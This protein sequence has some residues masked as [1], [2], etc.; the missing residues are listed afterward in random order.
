MYVEH[1]DLCFRQAPGM[2][3]VWWWKFKQVVEVV[4]LDNHLYPQTS[5]NYC[6]KNT[7]ND[8]HIVT[9][10]EGNYKVKK[11]VHVK[12]CESA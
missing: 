3:S 6:K 2:C 10:L 9:N 11:S 4:I 5:A 1:L 12:R 7:L 8:V